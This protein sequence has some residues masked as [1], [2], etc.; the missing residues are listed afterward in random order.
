MNKLRAWGVLA[1]VAAVAIAAGGW[2]LALSPQKSKVSSLKDQTAQQQDANAKLR[3]QIALLKKQQSQIPAEQARI[4][5][6]KNRIPESP[7][8]TNYVRTLTSLA[9]ATHVE[10]VSIAPAAP[11]Q[12]KLASAQP[13]GTAPSDAAAGGAAPAAAPNL[14]T[15]SVAIDVVGDYYNVQQFLSKLEDTQRATI[16]SAVS[17]KPGALPHGTGPSQDNVTSGAD[18]VA[19]GW[20]TLAASISASIFMSAA[21]QAVADPG[22]GQAEAPSTTTTNTAPPASPAAANASASN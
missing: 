7:Q 21:P 6:I 4:A 12:V 10:L 17:L 16:V 5:Q 22:A 18:G 13:Q 20:K 3:S 1:L 2:F 8:L 19:S 14:S 11:T 15:I 9:A